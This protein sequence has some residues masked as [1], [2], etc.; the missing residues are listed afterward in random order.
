MA[1]SARNS[2]SDAARTNTNN[3][4]DRSR[5]V[6]LHSGAVPFRADLVAVRFA[7]SRR[8]ATGALAEGIL[9]TILLIAAIP[10]AGG[11]GRRTAL[12]AAL[13]TAAA[14][15]GKWLRHCYPHVFRHKWYLVAAIVLALFVVGHLLGFMLRSA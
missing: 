8:A 15:E 12:I 11:A 7:H 4:T 14:I 6:A 2:W 3:E 9:L 5:S 10:G 1:C 13:L